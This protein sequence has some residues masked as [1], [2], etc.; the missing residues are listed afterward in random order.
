MQKSSSLVN[1]VKCFYTVLACLSLVPNGIQ[2]YLSVMSQTLTH[3][4]LNK[5]SCMWSFTN[6]CWRNVFQIL[7]CCRGKEHWFMDVNVDLIDQLGLSH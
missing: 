6:L 5:L 7:A 3:L 1:S 4:V 2:N